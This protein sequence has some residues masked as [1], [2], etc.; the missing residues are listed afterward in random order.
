MRN[1]RTGEENWIFRKWRRVPFS[2]L[3]KSATGIGFPRSASYETWNSDYQPL[4]AHKIWY[5]LCR[6]VDFE[7][8]KKKAMMKRSFS[9][10]VIIRRHT[11]THTHTHT[12]EHTH[13]TH[14]YS[15][16]TFRKWIYRFLKLPTLKYVSLDISYMFHNH[17]NRTR[18]IYITLKVYGIIAFSILKKKL[19]AK[20]IKNGFQ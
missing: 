11:H 12:H 5:E 19:K 13:S 17:K 10:R 4:E 3:E 16:K 18:T 15:Y 8:K 6:W 14:I 7:I 9:S 1:L 2:Q 20:I